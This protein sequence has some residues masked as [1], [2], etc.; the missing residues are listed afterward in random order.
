MHKMTFPAMGH[1]TEAF[2]FFASELGYKPIVPPKTTHETIKLGVRYSSDMVCFPFKST[3]G[4]LIQGLDAGADTIFAI[5][6]APNNKAATCRFTYYYHVQEQILRRLGYKFKML[7]ITDGRHIFS[8]IKKMNPSFGY[9]KTIKLLKNFYDKVKKIDEREYKFV[10]KDI[11]IGLIGEVYT[12]W[13]PGINYDIV[14]KLH[15]MGVGVKMPLTLS[16]FLEQNVPFLKEKISN[17]DKKEIQKYF[18]KKIGGH[19]YESISN[20]IR[21]AK[22]NFDGVIHLLPLSCMPETMVEMV[23]DFISEDY[24]IPVYRFPID[25]NRFEAGFD[26]RLETFIKLLKRNKKVK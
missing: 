23:I 5:G 14:N 12:L 1:Y 8:D 16:W 10:K 25:E 18:P 13:E 19:G 11:N 4:N 6:V 20:T 3:L 26:T 24:K 2:E 22:N 15:K 7:F 17:Y 21:F 9:L